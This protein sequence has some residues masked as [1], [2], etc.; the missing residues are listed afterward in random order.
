M[1]ATMMMDASDALEEKTTQDSYAIKAAFLAAEALRLA[2]EAKRAAARV[3]E[4]KASL[5]P[6]N[7]VRSPRAMPET[8]VVEARDAN[9]TKRLSCDPPSK[10][11]DPPPGGTVLFRSFGDTELRKDEAS[12]V[13]AEKRSTVPAATPTTTTADDGIVTAVVAPQATVPATVLDE[14]KPETTDLFVKML[15]AF[16]VDRLCGVDDA[17]LQLAYEEEEK[18]NPPRSPR[19]APS[20]ATIP[21]E[22]SMQ[23]T[24]DSKAEAAPAEADAAAPVAARAV[25]ATVA[26]VVVGT[27]SAA[28]VVHVAA[29]PVVE[30]TPATIEPAAPTP[31]VP[32]PVP[33]AEKSE[34]TQETTEEPAV[35][36]S[37]SALSEAA[38]D[39]IAVERNVTMVSARGKKILGV[40]R[41]KMMHPVL[42][43]ADPFGGDHD[44]FMPCSCGDDPLIEDIMEYE[45][46][47]MEPQQ[48]Q[49]LQ[50]APDPEQMQGLAPAQAPGQTI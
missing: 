38:L 23:E 8:P 41:S 17:S 30:A 11:S 34:P 28:A 37:S 21:E 33:V 31:V 20:V 18:K 46:L 27:V 45:L 6:G 12:E 39:D 5:S 15:D 35:V 9:Q 50:Q 25:H 19:A 42:A 7:S 32:T 2:E 16:G 36:P 47:S 40:S 49:Q 48:R 24:V 3:A 1:T 10:L 26:P 44:D 13:T 14:K 29:A 22:P 4:V 43:T